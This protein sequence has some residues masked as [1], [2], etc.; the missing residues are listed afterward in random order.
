MNEKPL[1]EAAKLR[2]I[3]R[4]TLVLWVKTKKVVGHKVRHGKLEVTM[5]DMESLDRHLATRTADAPAAVEVNNGSEQVPAAPTQ[6]D[7]GAEATV[8]TTTPIQPSQKKKKRKVPSKRKRLLARAKGA[9]RHLELRDQVRLRDWIQ[10]RLDRK[11]LGGNDGPATD[12]AA[13]QGG[14]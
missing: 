7:V 9:I 4:T 6:P 5:V 8:K 3:K 13:Q 14:Q 10:S 11:V 1:R 12:Q 2:D